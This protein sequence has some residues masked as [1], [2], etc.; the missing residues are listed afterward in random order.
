MFQ[1]IFD[2][3]GRVMLEMNHVAT[4]RFVDEL[5]RIGR[6]RMGEGFGHNEPAKPKAYILWQRDIPKDVKLRI[7]NL[8]L[9][10]YPDSEANGT[11]DEVCIAAQDAAR[12]IAQKVSRYFGRDREYIKFL[13][14]EN[15]GR[16]MEI[17][18]SIDFS[19]EYTSLREKPF[20]V[21]PNI[22]LKDEIAILQRR[23]EQAMGKV[24]TNMNTLADILLG[25][26]TIAL[27]ENDYYL[28]RSEE[29][30]GDYLQVVIEPDQ[31][32][33]EVTFVTS[34]ALPFPVDDTR[35]MS[36]PEKMAEEIRDRVGLV[37][38]QE[39]RKV[40]VPVCRP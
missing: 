22:P 5:L 29:N 2:P 27:M 1:N 35:I 26:Y 9:E 40:E 32:R 15:V 13:R 14:R 28:F 33:V 37:D 6:I 24:M 4:S 30:N 3:K 16:F 20:L 12:Y 11:K 39:N 31:P 25:K 34:K 17:V 10:E 21:F 36:D 7:Y 19:I 8:I 23:R 38:A 18:E